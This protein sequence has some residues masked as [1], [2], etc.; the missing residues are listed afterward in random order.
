MKNSSWKI[1]IFFRA[2]VIAVLKLGLILPGQPKNIIW[3]LNGVLLKTNKV[4][5]AYNIGFM[6]FIKYMII[7]RKS[8]NIRPMIFELLSKLTTNNGLKQNRQR[9]T[10]KMAEGHVLPEIVVDWLSGDITNK[11]ILS[12]T[13]FHIKELYSKNYFSSHAQKKLVYRAIKAIFNENILAQIT[14]INKPVFRLLKECSYKKHNLLILS[15]W[16]PISFQ[17]IYN[18]NSE[19]FQYFHTEN[20]FISGNLHLV[21]PHEDIYKYLL[22]KTNIKP[23]DTI[24]IDDKL[25]NIEAAKKLGIKTIWFKN[26]N[27]KQLKK[28]L[29]E[30]NIIS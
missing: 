25:E 22:Q 19:L 6:N 14:Y 2:L 27:F 15:N 28:D 23:E 8:P 13:K 11:E 9:V 16:E 1:N 18:L 24:F 17:K 20:I 5:M 29:K 12:K 7:D 21:K 4:K 10:V 30:H 3:D 26:G